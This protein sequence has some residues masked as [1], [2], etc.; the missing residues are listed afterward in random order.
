MKI[1]IC[2][3][4]GEVGKDLAKFLSKNHKIIVGSRY[5]NKTQI[6]NISYKK[7]DFSKIIKINQKVDLIINCIATHEF[8]KKKKI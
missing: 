2:G 4:N 3:G 1:L 5:K 8:S 7:I 6:K